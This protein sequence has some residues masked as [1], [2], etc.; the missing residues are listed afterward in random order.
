[1]QILKTLFFFLE[2]LKFCVLKF[3]QIVIKI[4]F[5]GLWQM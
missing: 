3:L 4:L 1:M 2:D 5:R